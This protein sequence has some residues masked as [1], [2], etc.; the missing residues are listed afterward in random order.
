VHHIIFRSRGGPTLIW[1]VVLLCHAHHRA[2][3]EDHF[4]IR[5]DPAKELTFLRPDGT[6]I[7]L[8]GPAPWSDAYDKFEK[9]R[10]HSGS[11]PPTAV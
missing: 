3:H 5:G 1:N 6:P 11:D 9:R 4:G 7:E 8:P 10:R 2:V